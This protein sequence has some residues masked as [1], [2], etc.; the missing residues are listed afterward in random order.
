MITP[1][2]PHMKPEKDQIYWLRYLL[3]LTWFTPTE[4]I[5]YLLEKGWAERVWEEMYQAYS[6]YSNQR[7]FKGQQYL[8]AN[9]KFQF[10][11][12]R[13][14]SHLWKEKPMSPRPRIIPGPT[15]EVNL[16]RWLNT[17]RVIHH[18]IHNQFIIP[19]S[20]KSIQKDISYVDITEW[21]SNQ[22]SVTLRVLKW[23]FQRPI[24]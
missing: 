2:L 14:S 15:L 9:H 17:K 18:S 20:H 24:W 21:L 13:F 22:R 19:P 4:L 10:H 3:V 7:Y 12:G 1:L 5:T 16:E 23:I 8:L 6:S 11:K